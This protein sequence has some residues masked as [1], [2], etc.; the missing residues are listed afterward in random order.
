MSAGIG[1]MRGPSQPENDRE[2][3]CAGKEQINWIGNSL[4]G[5]VDVINCQDGQVTV[6]TEVT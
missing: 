5:A 2:T 1:L 3:P 6:I 4:V